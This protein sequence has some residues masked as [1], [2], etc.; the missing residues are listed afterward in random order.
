[1]RRWQVFFLLTALAMGRT[2]AAQQKLLTLDDI[3]D[4][5]KR[6]NF[7]G[8]PKAGLR[9]SK[10][11]MHYLETKRD[12][13]GAAEI[14][15]VNAITGEAAPL[16]SVAKMEAALR[17]IP[18]I[19]QED[20]RWIISQGTYQM[21][22]QQTAA[23][24][25]YANDLFY[26]EFEGE[27]ALRLTNTPEEELE[28]DFSPDGR[29][30]SFVRGNNLYV[31]DIA[32]GRERALTA[33]GDQKILNGRL[34][35]VY[36]EELY[37]RGNFRAYWWSPDSTK[38]AYL[39]LDETQ[40]REF[41]VVDHIARLQEVEIGPY[42]KAGD[43]NPRVSLGVV[44]AAG[45]PT[46]WINNFRYQSEDFLI[47]RVDWTPDG[48][49]VAYQVQDREQ[50][51]LDL[52]L[53]DAATGSSQ[54]LF[55]ETTKA[56]VEVIDNPRWLKDGSF[57]WLSER[58]GYKHIYHY[59]A[60]GRLIGQITDGKWEVRSLHG[61]DEEKGWVYF[62]GTEHSPIELHTYR[63]K[64]KGVGLERLTREAGTHQVN[65][66]PTMTHYIDNWS[67]VNTP[68]QVRLHSADGKLVRTID[69]NRV[70]ALKEYQLGKV[71]FLQV[72]ARDGFP[73]EAM[74]IKPPDFD[75][76]KRY[77]VL[78]YV[79]GGPQAPQVRN[80]WGGPNYMWHQ[81]LAQKG[82]IIWICDNRSASGKGAESSWPVYRNFGQIELQDLEDSL[83]WLRSQPYVD[84]S[85]IGIWGWSFGGYMVVYA[86]THSKSFKVGIS[87]A[88]VTDW[89]LYDS[90]Y[91]ERYMGT[92]QNNPEG[93][94]KSSALRSAANL[95]GKLL[96]IHGTMDDNV[97]LQNT[98]QF[99]YELQKA[100]KQFRMMLYPRSRHGVIDPLLVKHMR[101]MMTEFILENL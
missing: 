16:F 81:M 66:N 88:P 47:S 10:D 8:S 4:P 35:W 21:N 96:I 38:I 84:S 17:R 71:E 27:S 31:V 61:I 14:L 48:K 68:I 75:P 69:E 53:A 30:V 64:L 22:A 92:P 54:V 49:K 97:H 32:T 36:Q 29:M 73:L 63:I 76:S 67:D 65:F 25:K 82:Y 93:Y 50:R 79:Y 18:G 33:D 55:R 57:L 3:Y 46:R 85:R 77:P 19:S 58:N 59:S 70:E 87:G 43:P 26:Y 13:S 74:M 44:S 2:A 1:M 95:H 40:V 7:S 56:W 78:C 37:G 62:S 90:V 91:T 34:D 101:A 99:A 72:K 45:G 5:A 86:M 80:S 51:W 15:K 100:G 94:D 6:I 89:R 9:W 42:P 11:G 41:A 12:P 23:L 39:K 60:E 28:A 98:I 52:V 20:A 83:N 24:I